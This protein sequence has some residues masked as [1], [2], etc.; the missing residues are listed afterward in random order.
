[1]SEPTRV[2]NTVGV[3][4]AAA[5]LLGLLCLQAMALFW[6]AASVGSLADPHEVLETFLDSQ[7]EA[8]IYEA[9]LDEDDPLLAARTVVIT[10][11]INERT[12]REV[13]RR[14]F[15]LDSLDGETPIDLY[16]ATPGGWVDS[17]FSIIDTMLLIEAPV[18]TW[19][20]GGCY[21]AGALILTS[22]TGR[23]LATQNA[24]LMVHAS[25]DDSEAQY[26]FD[27]LA[28]RRYERV[29]RNTA[30]LPEDWFPMTSGAAYYLTPHEALEFELIDE[31]VSFELEQVT[32]AA[33]GS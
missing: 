5:A 4:L 30:A 14:L 19:A 23:R 15:Y 1:M 3:W 16:I 33:T 2:L 21:S 13:S 9:T 11:V 29:W 25:M 6:L 12:A 27:R 17:A 24:I 32:E 10:N 28:K 26:S 31:I 8:G 22:G 18:N 20:I 7:I